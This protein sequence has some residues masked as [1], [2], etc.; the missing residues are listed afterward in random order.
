MRP[1]FASLAVRILADAGVA[2]VSLAAG[3]VARLLVA[4][5]E[6]GGVAAQPLLGIFVACYLRQGPGLS[7][8]KDL[9]IQSR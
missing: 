8:E 7:L 6:P 9:V 3:F 5:C 1:R 4:L 2:G